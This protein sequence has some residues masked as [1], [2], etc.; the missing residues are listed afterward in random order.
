MA[1]RCSLYKI[2]KLKI[3][4]IISNIDKNNINRQLVVDNS[5]SEMKIHHTSLATQIL[6]AE[7]KWG[8]LE[9]G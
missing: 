6:T 2:N 1:V 4:R 5:F 3:S 9:Q 8:P 7:H